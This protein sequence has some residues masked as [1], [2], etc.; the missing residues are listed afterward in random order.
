MK[1]ECVLYRCKDSLD[2]IFDKYSKIRPSKKSL[3]SFKNECKNA[4]RYQITNK[5]LEDLEKTVEEISDILTLTIIEKA[6]M[7][8]S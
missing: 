3:E 4:V 1:C 5:M 6:L 8:R 7:E 2:P